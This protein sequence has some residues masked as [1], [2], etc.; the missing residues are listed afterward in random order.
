MLIPPGIAMGR[1]MS[2][3]K[4]CP[5][6]GSDPTVY[7]GEVHCMNKSC[8]ACGTFIT[9]PEKWNSR[10]VEDQLRLEIEKLQ[11]EL[12]LKAISGTAWTKA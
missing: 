3:L 12:H 1:K 5:F 11:H 8:F 7:Q 9:S 2:D 6:C 4:P 10:P